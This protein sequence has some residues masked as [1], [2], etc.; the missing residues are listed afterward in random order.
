MRP[1]YEMSDVHF[2]YRRQSALAGVTVAAHKGEVLALLGPNGSGKTTLLKILLGFFRPQSG[3]V[4]FDGCSLATVKPGELA[5]RV[6]YVPQVHREAFGYTVEDVVLMGRLPHKAFFAP[7]S[8]EDRHISRQAMA[9]LRI[10]HLAGKPYTEISGGE[11][12]LTLIARAMA[13]GAEI[14]IMDEPVNGL[15]YGNQVRLLESIKRLSEDGITFILT[16]HNPDHAFWVADKVAL[17]KQGK[18]VAQGTP[19][20]IITE[21]AL[22]ELY[23]VSVRLQCTDDGKRFCVTCLGVERAMA[24]ES[25]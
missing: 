7:Y 20:R 21:E 2:S 25:L 18:V 16:T 10:V 22:Q 9:G 12:Q 14:F 8:A 6:A 15:D 23:G 11:R 3:S 24:G 19:E 4:V 13:Q 17:F 1:L 5:M